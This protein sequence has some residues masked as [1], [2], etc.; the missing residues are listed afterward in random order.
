MH[1]DVTATTGPL[2]HM[3]MALGIRA[4]DVPIPGAAVC[5]LHGQHALW[6]KEAHPRQC[7]TWFDHDIA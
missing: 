2:M 6:V 1:L 4:E 5:F 7:R 3:V